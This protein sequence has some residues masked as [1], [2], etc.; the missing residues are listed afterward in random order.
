MIILDT[1]VWIEF[2]KQTDPYDKS[3]QKLLDARMVYALEP[4]FGEL[5]QGALNKREVDVILKFWKYL[6][7]LEIS[8][9]FIKAGHHAYEN[10]LVSKGVRLVDASI[11]YLVT[12]NNA[13]L[14]T[15]DK[16]IIRFLDK[17]HL[18]DITS[19]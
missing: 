12:T 17:Q 8:E 3:V 14:W 1:S 9:L 19:L 10:K 5:L 16:K 11:V 18:Y 4:I 6:P 13:R 15:L 7:K 2:F